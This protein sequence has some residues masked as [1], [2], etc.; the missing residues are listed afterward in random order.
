MIAGKKLPGTHSTILCHHW[1]FINL[2][3]SPEN[4]FAEGRAHGGDRLSLCADMLKSV[5]I[6]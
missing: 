4:R 6:C 5:V 3:T 1:M 2:P